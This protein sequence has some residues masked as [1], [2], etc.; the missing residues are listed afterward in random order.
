MLEL[1]AE[2]LLPGHGF[3]VVG[4]DRVRQALT[5]TADL[6]ESLVDQTLAVMNA[7]GRLDDAIHTVRP[8]AGPGGPALPPP[9]YDE[10]EFIVHT[11]WRQYGGWWDGNPA[12]LKPAPERAL[13]LELAALAGGAGALAD[14]ALDSSPWPATDRRG[15]R[16]ADGPCAWPA[17]WPSTPGWPTP[18][19]PGVQRARQQVFAA[20]AARAT[21][22]MA[23]GVFSWAA[24]ESAVTADAGHAHGALSTADGP[25]VVGAR[26][27]PVFWRGSIMS[28]S[29]TRR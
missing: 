1:D 9:V 10:P 28:R 3:P 22:T 13:A 24:N 16:E 27:I 11:V 2:F 14:R 6:L 8:P 15:R 18:D 7:G 19:D 12:T 5:D 29:W 4:A 23:N 26:S 17:T 21:S 25:S 20:R